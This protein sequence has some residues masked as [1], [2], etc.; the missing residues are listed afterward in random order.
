[1]SQPPGIQ[2]PSVRADFSAEGAWEALREALF[3]P[4]KNGFT[5][6]AP[7]DLEL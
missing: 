3:S 2:K 5:A 1:M 7:G 4:S 6:E